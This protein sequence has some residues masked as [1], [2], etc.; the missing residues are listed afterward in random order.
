MS[1]F[2]KGD[3][4]IY[5][6]EEYRGQICYFVSCGKYLSDV[7]EVGFQRYHAKWWAVEEDLVKYS[8]I[9]EELYK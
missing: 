9:L 4:L 2:K 3:K 6:G 8:R 1:K 7:I 5:I